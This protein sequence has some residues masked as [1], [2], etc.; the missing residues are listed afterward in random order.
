[1]CMHDAYLVVMGHDAWRNFRTVLAS[2]LA[3]CHGVQI[4][5]TG[6]LDFAFHRAVLVEIIVDGILIVC[7]G[8]DSEE[9]ARK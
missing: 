5:D 9:F 6:E 7:Y 2:I 1:M 4:Q 3:F 8:A